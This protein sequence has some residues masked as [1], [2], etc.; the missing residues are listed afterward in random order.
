MSVDLAHVRKNAPRDLD[1]VPRPCRAEAEKAVETLIRW[2]GDDPTRG[3]LLDTPAR[4]VRAWEDW[5]SGYGEDPLE[6]LRRTFDEIED[7]DE[8]VM[9]R[10]IRFESHCEHHLAPIIGRAHVAYIPRN[11]VIGISKLARV[12]TVYAKRLQIQERMTAQ[13][14]NTLQAALDPRGIAVVLEAAHECMSTRGVNKPE[15]ATIT[16]RML[17]EFRDNEAT[18]REFY[19]GIGRAEL[20]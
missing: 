13:I 6:L 9:L 15:I 12:V 7:Y 8:M 18:R 16:S 14:A 5:F 4:V 20:G 1:G 2:A 17:G 3:G 19:A 11:R 10:G